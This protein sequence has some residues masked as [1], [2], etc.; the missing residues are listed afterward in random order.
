MSWFYK[1]VSQVLKLEFVS[2][3]ANTLELERFVADLFAI[4]VEKVSGDLVELKD[5]G[6]KSVVR[7][8]GNLLKASG[9]PQKLS[10]KRN[11][12]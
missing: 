6:Q 10:L 11:V 8:T 2:S 5:G 7:Q 4:G 3:L 1:T 9:L 12:T